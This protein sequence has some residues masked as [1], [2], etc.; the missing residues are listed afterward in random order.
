MFFLGETFLQKGFPKFLLQSIKRCFVFQHHFHI[1]LAG[2][3]NL[4]RLLTVGGTD[5]TEIFHDVDQLCRAAVAEGQT[6]LD[7]RG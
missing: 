6:P 3:Q 1:L 4:A 2:N 5:V 7:Q